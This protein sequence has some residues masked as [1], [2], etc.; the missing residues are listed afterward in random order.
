MVGSVRSHNSRVS[1]SA[2]QS[3]SSK[4][5]S[6]TQSFTFPA[7]KKFWKNLESSVSVF[8]GAQDFPH[9]VIESSNDKRLVV[10]KRFMKQFVK[11]WAVGNPHEVEI[12]G[13]NS[14]DSKIFWSNDHQLMLEKRERDLQLHQQ[15]IDSL[16]ND[17]LR[18]KQ[19][20]TT[21]V[22]MTVPISTLKREVDDHSSRS[23]S[24]RSTI[25][26]ESSI[27]SEQSSAPTVRSVKSVRSATAVHSSS[28]SSKKHLPSAPALDAPI[29]EESLIKPS[30]KTYSL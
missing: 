23:S 20:L 6:S 2:F 12:H 19:S 28:S 5:K 8:P 14:V 7:D 29:W 10:N 1:I 26:S 22:P 27:C 11:A 25:T 3:E 24:R 16:R 21:G 30:G 13:G 9:F 15:D 18:F 17:I 4:S